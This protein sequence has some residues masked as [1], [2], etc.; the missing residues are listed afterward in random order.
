MILSVHDDIFKKAVIE[1]PESN[2]WNVKA[3]F[4]YLT[5]LIKYQR[6]N[7]LKKLN[8]FAHATWSIP[9]ICVT[10]KKPAICVRTFSNNNSACL[11]LSLSLIIPRNCKKTRISTINEKHKK[12]KN[13]LWWCIRI[14][15]NSLYRKMKEHWISAQKSEY[16]PHTYS[17]KLL[18]RIINTIQDFAKR[19]KEQCEWKKTSMR[20]Y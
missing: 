10:L 11:S 14:K 2:K 9:Y 6:D 1:N 8:I 17:V 18:N 3:I 16:K 4:S 13:H 19:R 20:R 5:K 15:M 7:N 12:I